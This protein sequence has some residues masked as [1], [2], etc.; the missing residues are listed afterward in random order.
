MALHGWNSDKL[1]TGVINIFTE[2]IEMMLSDSRSNPDNIS[3]AHSKSKDEEQDL[4]CIYN[5]YRYI[6]FITTTG[7]CPW[8]PSG[9]S[10][11][12][13]EDKVNGWF[14]N[15]YCKETY[16]FLIQTL[17]WP[18]VMKK[19]LTISGFKNLLSSIFRSQKQFH[20]RIHYSLH[21]PDTSTPFPTS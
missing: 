6:Y 19:W 3:N 16:F 13:R 4:L 8:R 5:R 17:F 14:R 10:V 1:I 2:E 9:I 20:G 21:L 18:A 12:L 11:S 15:I 7:F